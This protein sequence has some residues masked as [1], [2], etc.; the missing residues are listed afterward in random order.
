MGPK[1]KGLLCGGSPASLSLLHLSFSR[2]PQILPLSLFLHQCSE[3]ILIINRFLS[4]KQQ[5]VRGK[6][7]KIYR[8]FVMQTRKRDF[9]CLAE[10]WLLYWARQSWMSKN[11]LC[12]F[13][14]RAV[15]CSKNKN[16]WL[17][18]PVRKI[19]TVCEKAIPHNMIKH[20]IDWLGTENQGINIL[21]M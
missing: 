10:N 20:C 19:R 21:Q 17:I 1:L 9:Y 12:K 3:P 16:S 8:C 2:D 11:L 4:G 14:I 13:T 6:Q 15:Q 18:N 7:T 5:K